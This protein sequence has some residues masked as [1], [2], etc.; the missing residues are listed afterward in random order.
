MG[1]GVGGGVAGVGWR[2]Q[3]VADTHALLSSLQV[4][5]EAE[6]VE[7]IVEASN[8]PLAIVVIGVGDGPWGLMQVR[9]LLACSCAFPDEL[10]V[11]QPSESA[12]RARATLV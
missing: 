10:S 12:L 7:A 3:A 11:F 5:N 1:D 2:G 8:Y 4:T 9:S 6:T